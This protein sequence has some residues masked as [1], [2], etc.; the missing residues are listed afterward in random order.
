V[1]DDD[2]ICRMQQDID[3]L[4]LWSI[5]WQLLFN[6]TTLHLGKANCNHVYTMAGCDIKQTSEEKDLG[7]IIDNQLKFH[8]RI[9]VTVSK[10]RRLLGMINKCFISLSPQTSAYLYKS[11]VRPCLE[12]DNIIWGPNYKGD[13]D[14]IEK[15]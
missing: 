10:A 4:V 13:E 5:K 1:V 9:V 12:Y 14:E 7:I 2:D 8:R 6:V 3:N 11:I 15:V